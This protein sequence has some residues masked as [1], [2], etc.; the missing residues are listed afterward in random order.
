VVALRTLLDEEPSLAQA[1]SPR[2]HRATLLHYCAANGVEEDRQ[3]PA[4]CDPALI[5][6][7]LER[8]ADPNA[9]C[10]LYGGGATTLGLVLTSVHPV[11][12]GTRLALAEALLL[13][14]AVID[15]SRRGAPLVS[16][17][18]LGD[19][20]MVQR[21]LAAPPEV[22]RLSAAS[23]Q[24]AF[25]RACEFGR[26]P[27]IACLLDHGVDL[28]AQNGSGQTGLHL[29]ALTGSLEAVR[30][31]VGRG[32]PL[33]IENA[34][35]GTVLGNV[36]WAAV[37]HDAHVD[38]APL[39]EVLVAAGAVVDAGYLPWLRRQRVL[40]PESKARIEAALASGV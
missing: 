21:T 35:G 24:H 5:R 34:W 37:N 22:A 25:W 18:A 23:I 31:L 15:G 17:A 12:A 32:A 10:L 29:A 2:P 4:A 16:A 27:V 14:G 6:A 8:G 30:L 1:R 38:Y 28:R 40:K 39:V 3:T 13:A 26:T 36:L 19:L 9:I 11:K 20:E 33:E 7:L